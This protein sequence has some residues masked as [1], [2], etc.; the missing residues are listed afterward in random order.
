[1]RLPSLVKRKTHIPPRM[2]TEAD[3][4][5]TSLVQ[6][7]MDKKDAAKM[8]QDKTGLSVVTG[9]KM[10]TRGYGWQNYK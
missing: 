4:M 10:K 9:K 2:P 1:M 3:K 6:G 5:Y 8:S 7:G